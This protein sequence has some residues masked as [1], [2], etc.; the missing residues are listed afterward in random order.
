MHFYIK[1]VPFGYLLKSF[2]TWLLRKHCN[3]QRVCWIRQ[4]NEA[5]SYTELLRANKPHHINQFGQS[6][7]LASVTTNKQRRETEPI[8]QCLR[9]AVGVLM[10]RPLEQMLTDF[11]C[12]C[13]I[14]TKPRRDRVKKD[15]DAPSS[16]PA[17]S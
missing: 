14:A 5:I 7:K 11:T 12:Y 6:S 9:A 8:R 1:P 4:S 2:F 15:T 17:S 10:E 13:L 16:P 3:K